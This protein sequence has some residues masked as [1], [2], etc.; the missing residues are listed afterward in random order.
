[1]RGAG[2]TG[3]AH[4]IPHRGLPPLP[5]SFPRAGERVMSSITLSRRRCYVNRSGDCAPGT[6]SAD[7]GP[8]QRCRG[9]GRTMST[10]ASTVRP[11]G[12]PVG[13]AHKPQDARCARRRTGTCP[14]TAGP[15]R[16]HTAVFAAVWERSVYGP[17]GPVVPSSSRGPCDPLPWSGVMVRYS[18]MLRIMLC[19]ARLFHVR[20]HTSGSRITPGI[21]ASCAASCDIQYHSIG[22]QCIQSIFISVYLHL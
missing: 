1:M 22:I 17:C 18:V 11:Q 16:A 4:P 3:G 10:A 19:C 9:R 8:G 2:R 6:M 21:I 5:R 15:Q 14:Q 13:R 12:M 20:Y 7:Q